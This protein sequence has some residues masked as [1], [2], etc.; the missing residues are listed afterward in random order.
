MATSDRD[1]GI[2]MLRFYYKASLLPS[3]DALIKSLD[4]HP[5]AVE[6]IG[7][8]ARSIPQDKVQAQFELLARAKGMTYPSRAEFNA[9]L[10]TAG[11]SI[12]SAGSAIAG[13]LSDSVDQAA[14]ALKIT[15]ALVLVGGLVLVG[16]LIFTKAGRAAAK[17]LIPGLG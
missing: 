6:S 10:L 15:G 17:D 12:V 5:G 14:S 4:Q 8:M 16:V 9:S 1:Y 13:G 11:A 2:N 3:L 7:K